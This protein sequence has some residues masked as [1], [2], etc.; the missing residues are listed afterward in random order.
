MPMTN[1][2]HIAISQDEL[3]D[4]GTIGMC[5]I[6]WNDKNLMTSISHLIRE[7]AYR[8]EVLNEIEIFYKSVDKTV[9]CSFCT[10]C[11]ENIITLWYNA[12]A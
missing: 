1:R 10:S 8:Y 7:K 6:V 9:L 4:P 5:G 11:V 12:N 2:Y 3:I